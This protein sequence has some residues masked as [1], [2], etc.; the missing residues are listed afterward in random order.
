VVFH[1]FSVFH[2]F[3]WF[4][5]YFCELLLASDEVVCSVVCKPPTDPP[6][7]YTWYHYR[8]HSSGYLKYTLQIC[9]CTM[10]SLFHWCNVDDSVVVVHMDCFLRFR[11]RLGGYR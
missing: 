9:P 1:G 5:T 4:F 2:R 7:W 10:D 11:A 8:G 3:W 6:T